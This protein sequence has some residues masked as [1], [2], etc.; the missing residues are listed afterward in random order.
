MRRHRSQCLWILVVLAGCVRSP[1]TNERL[2]RF[3]LQYGYRPQNLRAGEHNSESLLVVLTFSGGGT[4]AASLA[5]GV[6]EQLRDTRIQWEG[7]ERSLLD[8]VDVISSVSGGS[9]PAAYYGLF[10]KRVF[11][12]FPEKVLYKNL[13]GSL[14]SRILL[15]PDNV[16]IMSPF[17]SRTDVLAK[18]FDRRIF[19]NKTF[20]DLLHNGQRPYLV[21]N[22]TDMSQGAHFEFT[23]DQFDQLYSD[24]EAYHVGHAVAA[25]ACFPGAFPPLTV[26]NYKRGEDYRIPEWAERVLAS[27][28]TDTLAF[29]QASNIKSYG[30]PYR[31]YI[32]VSDGGISDNLGLLP[33]IA[34]LRRTEEGYGPVP[35][36]L[37]ERVR[38]LLIVT[39]NAG[40]KKPHSWDMAQSPV[41]LLDT[42]LTAST[43]PMGNYSTA[44]IEYLKLLIEKRDLQS[45]LIERGGSV[46]NGVGPEIHFVQVG[47]ANLS[48]P[49]ERDALNALPTSFKLSR[50]DVDHLRSAAGKILR[51]HP[52]FER[53]LSSLKES[54]R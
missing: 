44:M 25:S 18:K 29:R 51:E 31:R 28:D 24:L 36:G 3:D 6:L 41:G 26:R 38:V 8:E 13:Q 22:G 21:I 7:E 45:E 42:L 47:F 17:Y 5:Y 15:P 20:A 49:A 40:V 54:E 2:Q 30:E 43:A 53:F 16:K 11:E 12:D 52:G 33:V 19:E 23:Q 27:G 32:H 39:V 1:A 46:P 37:Y 14:T 34:F 10:G 35:G 50:D 9:L 4:R 48:D